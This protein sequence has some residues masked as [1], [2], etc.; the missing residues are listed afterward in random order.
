MPHEY[1]WSSERPP[2]SCNYIIPSV[3]DCLTSLKPDTILDLGAGNGA[4][5]ERLVQD[6][7]SVVGVEPDTKGIS[8]ARRRCPNT[9]FYQLGVDDPPD[10]IL[11]DHPARFDVVVSTEVIEHLYSPRRL[12]AFAHAV[13]RDG[14]HLLLTTPY[15]G[16][17]KNLAISVFNGWDRHADPLRDGGH[18][19]LFSRK[20]MYG[21]LEEGGFAVRK[22]GGVGRVPRLWKS[23]IVLAVKK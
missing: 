2:T 20:T 15:H 23:M 13:L 4:L 19:K 9:Q 3:L 22:F 10:A 11:R 16:Y 17:C 6:R 7:Y 5:C 21:L 8:I 14:G 18:I 12:V 1:G